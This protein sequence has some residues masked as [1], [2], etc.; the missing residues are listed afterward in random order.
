MS[1][2]P[3]TAIV[4]DLGDVMF[5]WSPET[6]TK[7]SGK[8]LHQILSDLTWLDYE[9]GRI[10]ADECHTRIGQAFSLDPADIAEAFRQARDSLTPNHELLSLVSDLKAQSGGTL[11]V[12]AMSNISAPDYEFLRVT[13]HINWDIFDKVFTSAAAGE[14][15]P[16]L[17]FYTH[18][19][20]ES[21][22]DPSR[23]VFIDDKVENVLSARSLG[24]RGIVFEDSIA[25]MRQLRN[26][27]GS[28][29]KRAWEFLRANAG[30]LHSVT[31]SGVELKEHFA[32]LLILEATH[33]ASL[34]SI[35]EPP[36]HTWNFFRGRKGVLTK[37]DFPDDLDTTSLGLTIMGAS[38]DVKHSILDQMLQYRNPDGIVQTYFDHTRPRL[39][40]CVCVNVLNLFYTNGRGAELQRTLDWVYHVLVHRAYLDGT[41][42]YTTAECFLFFIGRLL[43]ASTD[44]DLHAKLEP[45]FRERVRERIGADGDALALAMRIIAGATVG[46]ENAVDT[47][48]LL[49]MQ[50]ADGG[51]EEGWVYKLVAAKTLIGCR[52]LT[53]ALALQAI[54]LPAPSS[55]APV[56]LEAVEISKAPAHPHTVSISKS[57]SIS[58]PLRVSTVT[59]AVIMTIPTVIGMYVMARLAANYVLV[60]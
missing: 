47:R 21:G 35:P 30:R 31:N 7:I 16:N 37:T 43:S 8:T 41:R 38:E 4:L 1:A 25:V 51:W 45:V 36:S 60:R 13:K 48:K 3:L 33:D 18:V 12:F 55:Q 50:L 57:A 11:R 5:S 2:E 34:I 15:K 9:C 46:I 22:L 40:A 10:S 54:T 17:A 53:T 44:A 58:L 29:S 14:R 49:S 6:K 32:Q 39:D 27:C 26:L 52:G 42:Y 28:P 23:A 19:I 24:F 20:S 56:P 59:P